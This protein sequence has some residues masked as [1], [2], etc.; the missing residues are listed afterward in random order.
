MA[1]INARTSESQALSSLVNDPFGT[2]KGTLT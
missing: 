2:P 1:S